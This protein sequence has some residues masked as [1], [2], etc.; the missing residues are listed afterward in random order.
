MLPLSVIVCDIAI[1]APDRIMSLVDFSGSE[2]MAL[3]WLG[4]N[5]TSYRQLQRQKGIR[6]PMANPIAPAIEC[7]NVVLGS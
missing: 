2:K 5:R 3:T 7:P 1:I 4:L 6:V